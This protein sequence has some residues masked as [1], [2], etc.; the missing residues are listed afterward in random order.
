V[1]TPQI[2]LASG[3]RADGLSL[4]P[5]TQFDLVSK[6]FLTEVS[7]KRVPHKCVNGDT[8]KELFASARGGCINVEERLSLEKEIVRYPSVS[9]VPLVTIFQQVYWVHK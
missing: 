9:L 1:F 2:L 3:I 4:S 5:R 7:G 6:V 8:S